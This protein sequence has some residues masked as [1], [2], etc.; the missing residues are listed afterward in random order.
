MHP[1]IANLVMMQLVGLGNAAKPPALHSN[2]CS[3]S[4]D[5]HAPPKHGTA[6][7]GR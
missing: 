4:L 1:N 6:M 3:V 5:W 7:P 2:K